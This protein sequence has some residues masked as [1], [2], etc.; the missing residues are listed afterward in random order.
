MADHLMPLGNWFNYRQMGWIAS[1]E[2]NWDARL[3]L[4]E[5]FFPVSLWAPARCPESP[6][7]SRSTPSD[8][9]KLALFP[10]QT[11]SFLPQNQPL[12]PYQTSLF[13]TP[14]LLHS[15][16]KTHRQIGPHTTRVTITK[17]TYLECQKLPEYP[18]AT[19]RN[20]LSR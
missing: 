10:N 5:T 1:V 15:T 6:P 4:G 3:Q 17:P 16:T 12:F 9:N 19:S 2:V 14:D 7:L 8:G 18:S 20:G 11:S 13:P